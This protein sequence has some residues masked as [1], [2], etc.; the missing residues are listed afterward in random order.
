MISEM[1]ERKVMEEMKFDPGLTP[2]ETSQTSRVM[3]L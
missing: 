1:E 2:V 3:Y